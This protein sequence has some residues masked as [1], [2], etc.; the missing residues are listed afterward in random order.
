MRE[1]DELNSRKLLGIMTSGT[2]METL[3]LTKMAIRLDL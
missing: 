1:R 2:F 3:K